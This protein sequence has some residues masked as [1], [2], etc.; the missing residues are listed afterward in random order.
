MGNCYAAPVNNHSSSTPATSRNNSKQN[1]LAGIK[2]AAG[3]SSGKTSSGITPKNASKALGK[4]NSNN[5]IE[6]SAAPR[7][8]VETKV[9]KLKEFSLAELKKCTR[10]FR[11][12]IIVGVGGSGRV[13]KGWVNEDTY[14]PSRF[15][16][17]MAVAVKKSNPDIYQ[18]LQEW[19][20]T[21]FPTPFFS[22]YTSF[23]FLILFNKKISF[24]FFLFLILSLAE[25]NFLGKYR[26]PNLVRLLGYCCEENQFLLVYE[27]MQKG[28]LENHLFRKGQEPL[29]W[30]LR[31]KIAI[32]AARGLAFLHTSEKVI[33]R[34]FKTSNILLDS[35]Y[36]AKLSKFGMAKVGPI[37]GNSH[38]TTNVIG[39]YGYV[40]PEYVA[41][42]HLYVKSDVYGFGVVLLEM[43]TG[44]RAVDRNR[45]HGERSLVDWLRPSLHKKK[46]LK[47]IMDPGLGD[48]YPLKAACQAAELILKCLES[49]PKNRP[50][51]EE[52]LVTLEKINAIKEKPK[53]AKPNGRG[54]QGVRGIPTMA[55][56]S[57]VVGTG[58]VPQIQNRSGLA[59]FTPLHTSLFSPTRRLLEVGAGRTST[60]SAIDDRTSFCLSKPKFDNAGHTVSKLVTSQRNI[61]CSALPES[62]TSTVAADTKEVKT[63]QRAA[64]AKP[65]V[66]AKAPAKPLPQMME[67]DVIPQ[68]KAI[69]ETQD[70]LS[71]IELSFQDNKLEGFFLKKDI[72]YSFWAFFPGGVLTGPKGFSLSSYGQ[73]ASTVEPFLIDE[74]KITA[75]HIVFWVEKRL[76]AQGIIPVWKD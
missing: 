9:P 4:G 44:L 74:K 33:Y 55:A 52:V 14:A 22:T 38:V 57:S 61:V 69:L 36:N 7:E 35:A 25:L 66:A 76:A 49:D 64:P 62:S 39:T 26:H 40:A 31:L 18:G 34:D 54:R 50:S 41:T 46:E 3:N 51:M 13:F 32:G 10:R 60:Q 29:R 8:S 67:E 58:S 43:L 24:L 16:I 72:R 75:K 2:K 17:G 48:Q 5:N 71:D 19:Q 28:S 21:D 47:K 6:E 65:K 23:Y 45:P 53:T 30:E 42:G 73:G 20:A 63:A 68:L 12:D 1:G 59:P 37:N 27:Y 11:P 70:E 56:I 15:G